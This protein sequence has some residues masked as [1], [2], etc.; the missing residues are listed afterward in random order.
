MES[1]HRITF[2]KIMVLAT[3]LTMIIVNAL[4]NT[5][6]INGLSTGQISDSYPN[7]F[8]PAG[9]TFAIWGI[10]YFLLG[11]Y[12]LYHLGLFRD[13]SA[14]ANTELLNKIGIIFS[15]SSIANAAW[16]FSWHYQQFPLSMLLMIVILVCLILINQTLKD[17]QLSQRENLFVR[18]PF[19]VYFGWITVATIANATVLLVSLG[20]RDVVFSE[21]TW[22][23]IIIFVGFI[24]GATTMLKNR[25]IAYGLVIVWAY[26]GILLKHISPEGF[27]GQYTTIIATTIICIFLLLLCVTYIFMSKKKNMY[28]QY[29]A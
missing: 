10:I 22:A 19:S 2:I 1:K 18:L 4:A 14:T 5:L 11:G 24:I 6:P 7:L 13:N 8:A 20:W 28:K 12:T 25:D 27:G 26:A 23:V 9:L 15:V 21:A 29:G 3:F 17:E 16:V